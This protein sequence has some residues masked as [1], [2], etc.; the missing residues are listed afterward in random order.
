MTRIFEFSIGPEQ[1][2]SLQVI[3]N[4]TKPLVQRTIGKL[5]VLVGPLVLFPYHV[6]RCIRLYTSPS[7]WLPSTILCFV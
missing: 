7:L 6:Y 5:R 1:T 2:S 4:F 3:S